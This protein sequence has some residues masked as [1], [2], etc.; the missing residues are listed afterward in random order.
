MFNKVESKKMKCL[1][2]LNQK[3]KIFDT[4]ESKKMK[5]LLQLNQRKFT[6]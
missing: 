4:A 2:R 1:T 3:M 6:Q 5:H